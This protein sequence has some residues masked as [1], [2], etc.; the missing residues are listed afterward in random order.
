MARRSSSPDSPAAAG[1]GPDAAG[2]GTAATAGG[3]HQPVAGAL[4]G[5]RATSPAAAA[6]GPAAVCD[7]DAA[8]ADEE[9]EWYYPRVSGDPPG[10]RGY[11]STAA[12]EDGSKV[13]VHGWRAILL[14]AGLVGCLLAASCWAD[15]GCRMIMVAGCRVQGCAGLAV[16]RLPHPAR[17]T[18]AAPFVSP[19]LLL[20]SPCLLLR[21]LY[22]FG[23]ISATGACNTLAVL[24]LASWEWRW[25]S[26]HLVSPSLQR[27][28]ELVGG[29]AHLA[30]V[31]L[32]ACFLTNLPNLPLPPPPPPVS[33]SAAARPPTA[34]RPPPAAVTPPLST[35][36]GCGWWAAAAVATCCVAAGTWA[37]YTVWTCPPWWVV[38]TDGQCWWRLPAVLHGF[39]QTVLC[40]ACLGYLLAWLNG[41]PCSFV[42]LQAPQTSL[43]PSPALQEWRR[44]ALPTGPLCAGKCHASALVGRRL[45][46]FGGSMASCNEL[47]WLDLEQERWGAPVRVLGP[48]PC[49][50]MS[51][52]AVL[53]G[54]EV[55]VFGGYTFNYR[56]VGDV[57]RLH[58]LPAAADSAAA[59]EADARDERAAARRRQRWGPWW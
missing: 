10:A 30:A 2:V 4:G 56:E 13:G 24:D 26:L 15:C 17:A 43:H 11:H 31:R 19:P 51:A 28:S 3:L 39:K 22:V 18:A 45:L 27:R 29:S 21:Q 59:S 14:A 12:S 37:M 35:A 23:G 32:L 5:L 7:E 48:P 42:S 55:V 25:D 20:L 58:L 40:Y 33:P 57:H 50:R 8:L 52:T 6:A 16:H 49:E 54:E 41:Q 34:R 53:C 9:L 44:L 46:L 36:T 38:G 1:T 47:A